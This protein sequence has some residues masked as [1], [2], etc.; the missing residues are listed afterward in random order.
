VAG[1]LRLHLKVKGDLTFKDLVGLDELPIYLCGDERIASHL[2]ELLHTSSLASLTGVPNRMAEQPHIVTKEALTTIGMAPG[3]GLLPL[4]WNSFHG[5]NLL[6]EYFAC[7]ERFYFFNLK[8]L[9]AGFARIEG[10]EAEIV[11]LLSRAPGDLV[12]LTDARQFA[13]HCTPIVNL[14]TRRSDRIEIN[15]AQPEFHLL[16]DRSRPM[17][18]EVFS[19]ASMTAQQAKTTE[20]LTFRPLFQSI[21]QDEGN[22]GRYFSVRREQRLASNSSRKYGTRTSYTGTEVFISLVDQNEA[23]YPESLRYISIETWL[24][25][26]DLPRLVPRNGTDDLRVSDSI[27]VL[28]VGLIRAPSSPKAP[29]AQA[30]LAW[31]LI[32]QLGFN[33]LPLMDLPEREGAQALRD[34][35]KLFTSKDDALALRQIQSLIGSDIEPITGRL[36]GTGPLV[37]GRGVQI[38]L[39]VDEDGFSG[40]S[41]YLFGQILESYLS[42]HVAINMFTQTMLESMQR[43]QIAKWPVRMG[44]RSTV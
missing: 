21:N 4:A 16:P 31:R 14:F 10:N 33:Y 6:H 37:Y 30:E 2:Y 26:R 35:L 11:I 22:Y 43:G 34:M 23:P 17:D 32:R 36:P 5:H 9:A 7:P 8:H 18:F 12:G 42:R 1:S 41:P 3:E 40:V 38:K 44:T 13:L 24:T 19:V 28:S 27:P 29:F 15:P 20:A 39:S 25:N